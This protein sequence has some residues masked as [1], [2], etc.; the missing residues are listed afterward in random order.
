MQ[1]KNI[2]VEIKR[3]GEKSKYF[4]SIESLFDNGKKEKEREAWLG[5]KI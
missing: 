1:K 3:R 5:T 2:H 4:P